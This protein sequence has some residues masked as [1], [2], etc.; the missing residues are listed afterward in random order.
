MTHSEPENDAPVLGRNAEEVAVHA[1]CA[2]QLRRLGLSCVLAEKFAD[3]VDWH[4]V[5]RLLAR[6]CTPDVALEIAR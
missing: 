1:W 5:A 3:L 6:G 4:E 2:E